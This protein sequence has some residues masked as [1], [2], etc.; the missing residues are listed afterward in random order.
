MMA[1]VP[2]TLLAAMAAQ[3]PQ[4]IRQTTTG[5][6]SPI[7]SNVIGNVKVTCNGVDPRALVKLNV[8][9]NQTSREL[10]AKMDEAE[11]WAARYHELETRL[12]APGSHAE[13]SHQAQSYIEAG[14][15]EKAEAILDGILKSDEEREKQDAADYYTRGLASELD[16]KP[17]DAL[18]YFAKAYRLQPENPDYGLHYALA[19]LKEH[20][21]AK[22]GRVLEDV[23]EQER[24][25]AAKD[26][27]QYGP[28]LGRALRAKASLETDTQRFKEAETDINEELKMYRSL[29]KSN[30]ADYDWDLSR[31]LTNLGSIYDT[32]LR[33]DQSE[34]AY[35]EAIAIQRQLPDNPLNRNTLAATLNSYAVLLGHMNRD[36][37][38]DEAQDECVRIRREL[39]KASPGAYE[40]DLAL[41]LINRAE[42]LRELNHLEDSEKLAKEA[43]EIRTRLAAANP[44]AYRSWEANALS[45][46]GNV[47]GSEGKHEDAQAAYRNSADIYRELAR[48][49]AA[50]FEPDLALSLGALGME[51]FNNGKPDLGEA[52]LQEVVEVDRRLAQSSFEVYGP[53]LTENA[54]FLG[55]MYL[56]AQDYKNAE[57]LLRETMETCRRLSQLD[58]STYEPMTAAHLTLL[59]FIYL[60]QS[61]MEK[62]G[63]TVD[64]AIEIHK[65]LAAAHP[66]KYGD[67]LANEYLLAS[68]ARED[69]EPSRGC[70]L[71]GQAADAAYSADQKSAF[72]GLFQDCTQKTAAGSAK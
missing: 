71:L 26:P 62:A 28:G 18:P 24:E 8:R 36:K 2:L 42:Q 50:A 52:A 66:E 39:A 68:Q 56:K 40:P 27:V 5:W 55:E 25:L 63:A 9:L 34:A 11:E 58:R 13:L 38:E 44:D 69:K 54:G 23:L 32:T 20:Q 48:A 15:L 70:A 4:V 1:A 33:Y 60:Q 47:Y 3:Q 16:F 72:Q 10:T 37:D 53:R 57:P 29:A 45:I 67:Q 59:A 14:E 19:L 51:Y 6:C 22:A 7:I 41:A 30:P 31:A 43:V 17:L 64:E 35:K 21:Y 61:D 12:S 65:R 49:S 46:L